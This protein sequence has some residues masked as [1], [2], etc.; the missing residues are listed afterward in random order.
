MD[1]LKKFEWERIGELE[2]AKNCGEAVL[3]IEQSLRK[4]GMS[5]LAKAFNKWMHSNAM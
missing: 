2:K 1:E 4:A 3:V 5:S